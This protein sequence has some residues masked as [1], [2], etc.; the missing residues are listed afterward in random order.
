MDYTP[1][2]TRRVLLAFALTV[3]VALLPAFYFALQQGSAGPLSAFADTDGATRGTLLLASSMML[4]AAL[5][6][7][8]VLFVSIARRL[9]RRP[10][11]A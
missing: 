4:T 5:I 11:R 3:F 7:A 6:G 10:A 9:V 8:P 1:I 2:S